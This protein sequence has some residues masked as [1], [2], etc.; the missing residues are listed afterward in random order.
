MVGRGLILDMILAASVLAA[1]THDYGAFDVEPANGG[2]AGSAGE[3]GTS[4]AAGTG[5]SA[6]T[7]SCPPGQGDCNGQVSDGCEQSLTDSANHC[8]SCS[9]DCSLQGTSGGLVCSNGICGCTVDAQCG[10]LTQ[11]SGCT[12]NQTCLC[13]RSE[14]NRGETCRR[15]GSQEARCG[16]NG[17]GA[18]S[19]GF[20][21]CQSPSGCRDLQ[22]DETSCGACGR[23]CPSGQTCTGGTCG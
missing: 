11:G 4:G 3:G 16:C 6:G 13:G 7:L 14:C 10:Q 9:N 18:C 8:G 20:V 21:C 23:H 1:C 22:N 17:G 12:P 19:A 5:G 2:A 15:L